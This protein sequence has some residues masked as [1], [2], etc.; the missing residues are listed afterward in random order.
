[1]KEERKLRIRKLHRLN[2]EKSKTDFLHPEKC[3]KT[4]DLASNSQL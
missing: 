2:E 3:K 1:M 4:F